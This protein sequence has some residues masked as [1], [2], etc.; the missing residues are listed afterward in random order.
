MKLFEKN[1]CSLQG[2]KGQQWLADLPRVVVQIKKAYGLSGLKPVENLS[3][4][5]VL[6]GFRGDQPVVLK[7]GIDNEALKR[8]ASALRAFMGF[9]AVTVLAESDGMLLLQRAVPGESLKSYFPQSD[10]EAVS[11]TCQCLKRLH[12]APIPKSKT[13]PHI[14]D[15]LMILNQD[16]PIPE[17][18]LQTARALRDRLLQTATQDVLLHGDLHHDNILQN[19]DDWLVIDPK[20]VIGEAAYEV[21]AFIRN[22]IPEL[23]AV[24]TAANIIY[25]RIGLFATILGVEQQR[26]LD[27]CFVQAVL[28]WCWAI[29]DGLDTDATYQ[30]FIRYI[31]PAI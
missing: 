8:E 30:R 14:Q 5:Y 17:N 23:L 26:I 29:E 4:N 18:Y 19:G 2:K 27:W 21:A 28:S 25:H 1:I 11:I 10:N 24:D 6:S 12:Q 16:W 31:D 15:W 7:L 13:F 3:Y 22:P 9:G 20:G